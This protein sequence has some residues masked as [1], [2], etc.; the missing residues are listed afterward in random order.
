MDNLESYSDIVRYG[1]SF[2]KYGI[3]RDQSLKGLASY[4]EGSNVIRFSLGFPGG[5]V[6]SS[7]L[8]LISQ[9][10][11]S[12]ELTCSLSS[13]WFLVSSSDCNNN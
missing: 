10:S 3:L 2:F 12:S 4:S 13:P 5:G 7:S 8:S 6:A 11:S 1:Y 9:T